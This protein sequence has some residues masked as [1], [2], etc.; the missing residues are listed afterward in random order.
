[1]IRYFGNL[2]FGAS[3]IYTGIWLNQNYELSPFIDQAKSLW[4]NFGPTKKDDD[5]EKPK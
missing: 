1:M 5:K 2:V 3:G 4:A